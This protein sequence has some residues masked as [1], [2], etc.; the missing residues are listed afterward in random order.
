MRG[1]LAPWHPGVQIAVGQDESARLLAQVQPA[2]AQ[3]GGLSLGPHS[4]FILTLCRN[5]RERPVVGEEHVLDPC[6]IGDQGHIRAGL[7]LPGGRCKVVAA[8]REV[9]A[10]H[11]LLLEVVALGVAE[12]LDEV[13]YLV[14]SVQRV[15]SC[16]RA[17]AGLS[18][19]ES[20]QRGKEVCRLG[21]VGH[22][23]SHE[24][25]A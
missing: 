25:V 7:L 6:G 1:R 18:E 20:W 10:K 17:G 13:L 15:S 9:A 14:Q 8:P 24:G 11:L 4:E 3:G 16:Q 2:V 5:L 12:Q 21:L 22:G 23:E 19:R